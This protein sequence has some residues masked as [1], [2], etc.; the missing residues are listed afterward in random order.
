[1]K[2]FSTKILAFKNC[3]FQQIVFLG[4]FFGQLKHPELISVI[5]EWK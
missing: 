4:Q 5:F 3:L 2:E 1:M